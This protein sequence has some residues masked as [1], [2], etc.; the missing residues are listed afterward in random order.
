MSKLLKIF[1]PFKFYVYKDGYNLKDLASK[2]TQQV[3]E[4]A[5]KPD[6][7][8]SVHRTHHRSKPKL[9][10]LSSTLHTDA[11]AITWHTCAHTHRANTHRNK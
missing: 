9:L 5:A 4:V 8:S 11:E 3:K 6:N 7:L 10:K 2:M 1:L